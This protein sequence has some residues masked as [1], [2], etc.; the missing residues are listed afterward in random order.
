MSPL[1][2]GDPV[3]Q[4]D[5]VVPA[6]DPLDG[7][8][9]W[10]TPVDPQADTNELYAAAHGDPARLRVWTYLAQ[11]PF[12]SP[13]AMRAWLEACGPSRDP[14]FFTVHDLACQSRVGMTSFMRIQ[15]AMRVLELGNI[16]YGPSAQRTQVNTE[17]IYL[18]LCRAFD[19]LNYRR[20][21]WKC[22]ALNAPSRRAALRLGFQFEGVFRQ[23]MI[24]KGRNRDTA[25]FALLDGD[26]ARVKANMERWLYGDEAGLSLSKLNETV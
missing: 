12:A 5:T 17:S 19:E 4:I 23:H 8:H 14:L 6:H 9:V 24:V 1:P 15:P 11:G 26:W 22:N 16:W 10:L 21:E 3:P 18:M 25:W 2:I 13:D 20:V 7:R